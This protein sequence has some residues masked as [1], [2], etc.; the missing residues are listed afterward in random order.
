MADMKKQSI[1][2]SGRLVLVTGLAGAGYS[3]ALNALEDSGYLAVDNLPLALVDT[4]VRAEMET[5]D[6]KVAISIDGR[7][8]DFEPLKF[9]DVLAELRERLD[10]R[11]MM[12]FLTASQDELSCR[13]NMT[14]RRHP[15]DRH[16]VADGLMAA[17]ERD[18]MRM[19]PIE[20]FAD[21]SIDTTGASPNEFRRALLLK[22]GEAPADK[23]PVYIQSFSYRKGIPPDVDM[24]LDMRF[25]ANPHWVSGLAEQTGEDKA[26][27][28]Y[29]S[30]DEA[31]VGFMD[32]LE[33]LL[34]IALARFS[35]EG[36]PL[37]SIALGC[38]GG[39]HRSVFSA[40]ELAA[41]L[42]KQGYP[43]QL[44]HRDIS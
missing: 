33:A 20:R 10:G 3:T 30:A 37:F 41:R 28:E 7:A 43:V 35:T 44:H 25:L 9:S 6:K 29:I 26:V 32:N 13:Y 38:T 16:G 23:L 21:V 19:M 12:V 1:T 36:K 14:R 31:F 2:D 17:L 22:I 27:Q 8:S 42:T 34:D 11:V 18:S 24:T 4:L 15:L 40:L 39:R 5:A